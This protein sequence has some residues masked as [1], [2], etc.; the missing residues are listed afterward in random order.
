M[1]MLCS[2][3]SGQTNQIMQVS[4]GATRIQCSSVTDTAGYNQFQ[5]PHEN[6]ITAFLS[7]FGSFLRSEVKVLVQSPHHDLV[8]HLQMF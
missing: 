2:H 7:R 4:H 6:Q 5:E 3:T 8:T 1:K